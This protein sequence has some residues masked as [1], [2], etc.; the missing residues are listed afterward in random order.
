MDD[1]LKIPTS[2]D[3]LGYKWKVQVRSSMPKDIGLEVAGVCIPHE[4]KIIVLK[5]EKKSDMLET[6]LHECFHALIYESGLKQTC[7]SS[8]PD[9]E[10]LIV[11]NLSKWIVKNFNL[12][13]KPTR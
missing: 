12:K 5:Q 10:E 2:I 13:K 11:E 7:F 6:F 4:R 1:S 8:I 9:V 3:I